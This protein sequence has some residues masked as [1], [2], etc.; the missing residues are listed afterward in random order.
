MKEAAKTWGD[1]D[2]EYLRAAA[3]FVDNFDG[4]DF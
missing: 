1:A 2:V 4:W 3:T